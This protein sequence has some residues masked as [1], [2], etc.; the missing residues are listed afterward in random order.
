MAQLNVTEL[1]FTGI[2]Q[3]LKTF[4]SE[5]EEFSDY[6]FEGSAMSVL[7]DVLAYNTHYNAILAHML[8]NESFL[9][10]AV[11]RSSVVS[12]AKAIGY[13]P[14]SRRAA[15]STITLKITP[16]TAYTDSSYTLSRNTAFSADKDGT[17]FNFY[18]STDA[19]ATLQFID[20]SDVFL[21]EN[22]DIKEGIRITN[23]FL[24][25]PNT[26][27]GPI[28][29][30]NPNLDTTTLRVRVQSST[31]D[32]TISSY[33]LHTNFVDVIA[34]TKAFFLEESVDGLYQI[35]FGDNVIGKQLTVGNL[36]VIDYLTSKAS[37]A[38]GTL[39]FSCNTTLTG[40]N[41]TKF[42]TLVSPASGGQIQ[43]SI[44]SIRRNAPRYN[45][46]KER[47]VT[48]SDY[49][50]LIL[51]SNVNIQ[52]VSVWGGENNDPPIYGKV[53]ISLNPVS[54]SIITQTDKDNIINNI[55]TPKSTITILP[56][57]VDPEF[58]YISIKVKVLYDSKITTL[59]SGQI[60]AV[61]S[62]AIS[63]YFDTELN[64][65]N[66]SFYFSRLHDSIKESDESIISVNLRTRLQKR[67]EISGIG[68]GT[69]LST[70]F[71]VKIQP[72][73]F[74]TTWFDVN[75]TGAI[76]KVKIVDVPAATVVYPEYS[77][78]G[79]LYLQN[80]DGSRVQEIGT[81]D[82]DTGKI[83]IPSLVVVGFYSNDTFIRINS[84]THEDVQD[85][86]TGILSRTTIDNT[87]AVVPTPSKN[88]VLVL[89]DS[90]I[91]VV[92]GS[93]KGLDIS[94]SAKVEDY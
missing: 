61:S 59:T 90:V 49:Q 76:Y 74:Q 81:I 14:R 56:E 15:T 18:P 9:D 40:G 55:I 69:N 2:K 60:S 70:S 6:N 29:I 22:L 72:G 68:I 66:K 12:L 38:N 57:F 45:T 46:T 11:K 71:N 94:V 82:Y 89:D 30:P 83:N 21:F 62:A 37:D 20:G 28:L 54:G 85:I 4:L 80:V 32:F 34:T 91:D 50:S 35:R 51:A 93:R 5:Q 52:S 84:T 58:T 36:V 77:G 78:T 26:L 31:T 33:N 8:A 64:R 13:T 75:I 44:D 88:T 41:E 3:S 73:E 63:N 48:S 79:I 7:L 47:A 17:T 87:S 1:D 23:S 39:N 27:S 25:T 24:I 19:R 65:L 43:E 16:A 42:I 67:V 53:F 10:T 86:S 92:S